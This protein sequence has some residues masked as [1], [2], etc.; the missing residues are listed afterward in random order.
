MGISLGLIGWIEIK[1]RPVLGFYREYGIGP[2]ENV[3]NVTL[4]PPT[5]RIDYIVD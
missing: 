2:Q 3:V 5:V 4:L 1:A